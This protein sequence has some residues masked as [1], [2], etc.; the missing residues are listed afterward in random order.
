MQAIA[1]ISQDFALEAVPFLVD[2]FNDEITGVRVLA[3][4]ALR[5]MHNVVQLDDEQLL[6]VMATLEDRDETSRLATYRL[7]SSIRL[8]SAR[9]LARTA[10]ALLQVTLAKYPEDFTAIA[11]CLAAMGRSHGLFAELVAPE[12]LRLSDLF[13][14]RQESVENLPY[15]GL[16]VLFLSASHVNPTLTKL[17]PSHFERYRQFLALRYPDL[18][19]PT[20]EDPMETSSSGALLL[21]P[22]LLPHLHLSSFSPRR[23]NLFSL[24]LAPDRLLPY[25]LPLFSGC[26]CS[27]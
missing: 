2:T 23:P 1:Q 21:V 11:R 22:S 3:I 12:L 9:A 4:N 7:L 26:R 8:S 10:H 25:S 13:A 6:I 18:L 19:K 5:S 24:F 17:L 16:V 15:L 14:V 20:E 27:A